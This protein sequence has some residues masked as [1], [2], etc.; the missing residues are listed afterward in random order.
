MGIEA[1]IR[2]FAGDTPFTSIV[3]MGSVLAALLFASVIGLFF[4]VY[5]A[6]RASRM[7]TAPR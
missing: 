7:A 4:G 5:P 2:S 3:S 6:F 1:L